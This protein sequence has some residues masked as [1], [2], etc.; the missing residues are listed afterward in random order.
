VS[1]W[2]LILG[3]GAGA[4]AA[5]RPGPGAAAGAA[6]GARNMAVDHTLFESVRA[7]AQPALRLY[8]WRPACLSFGRNQHV[9]GLY[10]EA[11]VRAA[12]YDVVR[13]PTGGLAVLHDREL[14]YCVL[15]PL[16]LFGGARSAYHAIN[17]SL[18]HALR[19]LGVDAAVA[20]GGSRR[21]P[22]RD[23]AVPCFQEPAAGEVVARGGKLVGSAQRCERRT[24][25]QHGSILLDG[26]QHEV[27]RLATAAEAM[28]VAAAAPAGRAPARGAAVRGAVAL[29]DLLGR[30]PA[31]AALIEAC[32]AGFEHECGISLAPDSLTPAETARVAE[33]EYT[34]TARAW[35]WR[36]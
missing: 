1:D 34:Y 2:R 11:A 4:A 19:L 26:T 13:R 17:R 35:T 32:I 36:L 28:G 22:R 6:T 29:R 31:P 15:A 12:G 24:L 7:G 3:T 16:G 33:L 9:R 10:H 8:R 21:D 30:V 23:A 27:R 5:A 20:A 25:L 18:V 14:T